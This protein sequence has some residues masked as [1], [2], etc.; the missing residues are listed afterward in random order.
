MVKAKVKTQKGSSGKLTFIVEGYSVVSDREKKN[1]EE[2]K[3]KVEAF[4]K[5]L[6]KVDEK[7]LNQPMQI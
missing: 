5:D 6:L 1:M 7:I 3:L 4:V 2:S